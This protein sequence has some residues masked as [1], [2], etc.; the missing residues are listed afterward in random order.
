MSITT[1]PTQQ[2][3]PVRAVKQRRVSRGQLGLAIA[4][5]AVF[6]LGAAA[7][8]LGVA[9]AKPV[10]A[11]ARDVSIGQQITAADLRTVYINTD[12]GL[13]PVPADKLNSVIGK[14]AMTNMTAG[15]LL[16]ERSVAATALPGAGQQLV[17]I[18]LKQGRIPPGLK[19][20]AKVILVATAGPQN[21]SSDGPPPPLPEIHATVIV[22]VA[23]NNDT[24][25]SVAVADADGP[26]AARLA[27]EGRL[28]VTLAGS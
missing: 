4:L 16:T 1:S 2:S 6:A 7:L 8:V 5:A 21:N 26:V 27:A 20:G 24:I 3:I 25:L 12:P 9:K 18:S 15:S 10:L 23:V 22:A 19:P 17:G 28:V 11:I 14:F 13:S